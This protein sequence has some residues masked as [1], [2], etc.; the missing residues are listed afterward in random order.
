MVETIFYK[1]PNRYVPQVQ[2]KLKAYMCNELWFVCSTAISASV[3]VVYFAD[4]L[5]DL[6]WSVVFDLYSP[7]KPKIPTRLHLSIKGLCTKITEYKGTHTSFLCEVPTVTGEYGT[8]TIPSD[9][10]SPFAPAPGH[11]NILKTNEMITEENLQLSIDAKCAFKQC[12]EVLR[13]PDK[14]LLVLMLTDKDRKQSSNVPYSYPVA[15]ALKG[16]SMSNKHL[17]DLVEK[18]RDELLSRKIPVLCEAYDG[19][20][21]KF[22]TEDSEGNSLTLL[23]GR[24]HWN[25]FTNMSKDKCIEQIATLLLRDQH[26]NLSECQS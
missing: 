2:A 23:H 6:I 22:I 11:Q 21:H 5:W 10:N 8:V 1:V 4:K 20:W 9:F 19:Q 15:Y 14:E 16:S 3:I 24:D 12:H 17:R 25:R 13:D 26:M 7:E 18:V